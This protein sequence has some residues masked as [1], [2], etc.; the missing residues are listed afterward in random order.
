MFSSLKKI[1]SRLLVKK[2]N[3]YCQNV[4]EHAKKLEKKV[5]ME[6]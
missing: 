6:G 1:Q 3:L 5:K 4:S 2:E